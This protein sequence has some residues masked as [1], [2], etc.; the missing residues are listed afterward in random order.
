VWWEK[1]DNMSE[2]RQR[3]LTALGTAV[4]VST[5]RPEVLQRLS[6][7]IFNLWLDV[8]GELKEAQERREGE[9]LASESFA[10]DSLIRFWEL[11]EPPDSYYNGTEG[12]LEYSRRKSVYER[13]PVRIAPL[14]S[15]VGTKLREAESAC[16]YAHFQSYMRETDPT[17]LKQIQDFL[18][19]G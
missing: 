14:I 6:T 8:F 10:P 17:V 9:N 12:T 13:D 5:A 15:F 11:D 7:D 2:P 18:A 3:K 1:F 16:G 19:S 4:L